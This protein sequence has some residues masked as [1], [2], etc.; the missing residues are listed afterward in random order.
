MHDLS[1][2]DAPAAT[3]P[4]AATSMRASTRIAFLFALFTLSGFCGLI[5]ESIW[6]HYL[7]L[8]LG[9]AA[10]AQTVVLIVF[11]GG[12]A[13]GAWLAGRFASRLRRPLRA[14]AAA[15]L[16]VG[17][18]ALL[19]HAFFVRATAWAYASLLPAVCS[20]DS[21]CWPQWL[22]AA[23]AILPQSVLLGTTFPLMTTGVLRLD[24]A[25]P[26][27]RLS[28][29]YFLNSAGAVAGVLA[30][31]YLLI[32][33]IGL[34]GALTTAGLLNILLALAVYFIDRGASTPPLTAPRGVEASAGSRAAIRVLLAIAL[35]T[36]LSSFIYEVVWIR[37]LS[38][39]LGASTHSFELMLAAFIAGIALGGL[40]IGERID[41]IADATR[42]LAIVQVLMGLLALSTLPLYDASFD[43]MGWT[44]QA[45]RFTEPG[46][47][48]FNFASAAICVAVMLPTT[49]LAGMTL[50]LI[51]FVLLRSRLG[52]GSVGHVYAS[53]TLGGIL[54][55]IVAVH[56]GL[57]V[58]GLK[59]AL[60]LGAAIDIALGV[61]L[62]FRVRAPRLRV[63]GAAVGLAGI[64][65]A[66][67]FF[68]LDPM[69]LA[70]SVFYF[71]KP[72][73]DPSNYAILSH[74]DGRSATVDVM[75]YKSSDSVAIAT[76]GKVDGAIAR[77]GQP[78]DDEYTMTLMAALGVAYRPDARTVAVIGYGTGMSTTVVLGSPRVERV[79]TIE[80]EPAMP[81]GARA[82]RFF[83]EP[84][85]S[86]PRSHIVIDDAKSYFARNRTR[87]DVILSE[88]SNPWVSGVSSLF[89]REFYAQARRQLSDGGIFVQW[90][91]V[92]SF[93]D[94][95]FA[96]IARAL[97]ESFPHY[98]LYAANGGDVLIV[99]SP[100]GPLPRPSAEVFAPSRLA[101]YL[102]RIDVHTPQ[103]L[104]VRMV[105]DQDSLRRTFMRI[106][107]APNS[108][109][110]PVVDSGAS[111]ARF[112][113]HQALGVTDLA[114]APWPILE[115][116]VSDAP[117]WPL[118]PARRW[119]GKRM[120]N[121]RRAAAGHDFLLGQGDP[122]AARAALGGAYPNYL[123]FRLRFI[124]CRDDS[125]AANGWTPALV[126]ASLESVYLP[127]A[128]SDRVWARVR[129]SRCFASLGPQVQRWF[130]V[131]QSLGRRDAGAAVRFA[132]P[133]LDDATSPDQAM[134]FYGAAMTGL[135]ASGRHQ[136]ALATYRRMHNTFS[137][138]DR[139]RTW[140]RWF[141]GAVE[142]R[143][144]DAAV[145]ARTAAR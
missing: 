110:F 46:W 47:A 114:D 40:W 39:V 16:G 22:A 24:G 101:D 48:F 82:F 53:N 36:G 51:T 111:K 77:G 59:G 138:D 2:D 80:I 18:A 141:E 25:R 13:L 106:V 122:A 38:L 68:H 27:Q 69:K 63:A 133:A 142:E 112:L 113:N 66:T 34:P 89:S 92:Y 144:N 4:R 3:R 105:G 61:Y 55:V 54:G 65:A 42:Y 73:L 143:A 52:E 14:Y 136:E 134:Y 19:F 8:F 98:A 70:S 127:P 28:M 60:I 86:D 30:S 91:H 120:F 26:G 140:M 15:E 145:P 11:I 67:L 123:A 117:T 102:A 49:F 130:D 74:E 137:D 57:P 93:D 131:F 88:P 31:G 128:E 50:P 109:Y 41:R 33:S 139:A 43:V 45:L 99:A 95:L 23:L 62:L 97:A 96:S 104:Q 78:G 84:A 125:P 44:V 29:L 1:V 10:Y 115:M 5:Y 119:P 129:G 108:D 56:F 135:I 58:L 17:L 12:L 71:G 81:R 94:Y 132:L 64:V 21:W 7:K 116:T 32:P 76:N 103:D 75:E 107:S 79:D 100:S 9:H 6:S 83:T 118:S 72:R 124:D 85:Y 90:T 121:G 37:S 126:V 35:L 20:G 87:Y